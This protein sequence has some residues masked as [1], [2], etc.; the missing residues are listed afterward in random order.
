M[1]IFIADDSAK[2][3]QQLSARLAELEGIQ[4][5]GGAPNGVSAVEQISALKP[6][7]VILDYQMPGYTGLEV[8]K[9]IKQVVPPPLAIL[10][11]NYV[12]LRATCL[13]AGAD[14]FFDKT[15]EI[16]ELIELIARLGKEHNR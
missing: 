11:T 15:C 10:L 2:I 12:E 6:D 1:R 5:V 9:K 3:R 16:N 14:Y 13:A 7:V 4:V 8:L